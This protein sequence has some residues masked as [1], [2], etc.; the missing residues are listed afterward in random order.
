MRFPS[1]FWKDTIDSSLIGAIPSSLL[2]DYRQCRKCVFA[3][4]TDHL[5]SRIKNLSLRMPTDPCYIFHAFDCFANINLRGEDSRVVLSHGFVK[6]QG[7]GGVRPN[8][9]EYFN[10][11]SI[12]S[13]LVMNQLS[14]AIAEETLTYFYTQS[15]NQQDFYRVRELKDGLTVPSSSRFSLKEI[16]R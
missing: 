6:S 14:A 16:L 15:C 7:G 1:I 3:S 11:D 4:V 13:H 5:K 2:T 9:S 10:T 12:D 8:R